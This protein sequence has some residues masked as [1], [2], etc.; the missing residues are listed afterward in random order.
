MN[1]GAYSDVKCPLHPTLKVIAI[2]F[3][4]QVFIS[5]NTLKTPLAR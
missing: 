4:E 5:V 1:L 3:A 2:Y